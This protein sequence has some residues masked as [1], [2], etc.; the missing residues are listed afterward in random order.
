MKDELCKLLNA[1]KGYDNAKKEYIAVIQDFLGDA[2][3]NINIKFKR[4]KMYLTFESFCPFDNKYLLKFCNEFGLLS[5]IMEV[6][7]LS[8]NF[9]LY[10][11]KF[12]KILE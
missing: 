1:R 6:K 4:N 8:P 5:P 11:W 3:S 12:I 9:T 2:A 10:Y 7:E